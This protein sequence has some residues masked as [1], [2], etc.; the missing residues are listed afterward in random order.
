MEP[1]LN[2]VLHTSGIKGSKLTASKL[3]TYVQYA[4]IAM[5]IDG[6]IEGA[7]DL[8]ITAYVEAR[9]YLNVKQFVYNTMMYH[10]KTEALDKP[11][12]YKQLFNN[13]INETVLNDDHVKSIEKVGDIEKENV[14]TKAALLECKIKGMAHPPMFIDMYRDENVQV[15]QIADSFLTMLEQSPTTPNNRKLVNN[16]SQKL[17]RTS[18]TKF[19][20]PEQ[21]L[22]TKFEPISITRVPEKF[23][24]PPTDR[25]HLSLKNML[26][27]AKLRHSLMN[28]KKNKTIKPT[29]NIQHITMLAE[30]L[31][32]PEPTLF[33]HSLFPLY[34]YDESYCLNDDNKCIDIWA[35]WI[36]TCERYRY[37]I[38]SAEGELD[39]SDSLPS[40]ED[41]SRQFSPAHHSL[42]IK[43]RV[44]GRMCHF[45]MWEYS[46][47]TTRT[48][49]VLRDVKDN[50]WILNRGSLVYYEE[51]WFSFE[52]TREQLLIWKTLARENKTLTFSCTAGISNKVCVNVNN[53]SEVVSVQLY[54]RD[55]RQTSEWMFDAIKIIQ[56]NFIQ[57][58][59]YVIQDMDLLQVKKA[60]ISFRNKT[61]VMW[62]QSSPT[63]FEGPVYNYKHNQHK[64]LKLC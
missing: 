19:D 25:L 24:A 37:V 7:L 3:S 16:F 43:N 48:P 32:E 35:K 33:F 55:G 44:T 62:A 15:G 51:D 6:D 14:V 10:S 50:V 59:C 56:E 2:V 13:M 11:E 21:R 26:A 34:W 53:V 47:Q 46:K 30:L 31:N 58:I 42:F 8:L 45:D 40:V 61:V 41:N 5:L 23:L 12:Y 49:M 20:P 4:V 29:V 39:Y 60:I 63:S 52:V 38:V 27:I 54:R 57:N 9:H 22:S 18:T 36:N 64:R 1:S 28:L 17:W